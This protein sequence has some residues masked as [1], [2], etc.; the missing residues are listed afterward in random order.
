[1]NHTMHA[2]PNA[3]AGPAQ[4]RDATRRSWIAGGMAA[5]ALAAAAA[6]TFAG[7][8]CIGPV[9]FLLLG[10]GGA[11]AAAGVAPYRGPLLALSGVLIV[12]GYWRAYRSKVGL[13]ACSLRV[14]RWIRVSLAIAG[15]AWLIGAALWLAER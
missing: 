10:A 7:L 5:G 2:D 1:M 8:C 6:A 14:G 12:A 3:A 15:A 9:T 4:S 13:A 11:V